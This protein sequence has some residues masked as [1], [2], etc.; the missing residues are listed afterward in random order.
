MVQEKSCLEKINEVLEEIQWESV[1]L[2]VRTKAKECLA[3]FVGV[4]LK[5]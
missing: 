2:D 5:G 3:D 1:P 4:M